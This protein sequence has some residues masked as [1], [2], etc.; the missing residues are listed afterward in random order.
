MSRLPSRSGSH[1]LASPMISAG[2][3]GLRGLPLDLVSRGGADRVHEALGGGGADLVGLD[4]EGGVGERD[5]ADKRGSSTP[6]HLDDERSG[7][8]L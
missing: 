7:Q 4:V 8:S 1:Q 6:G 3:R 5:P 2:R